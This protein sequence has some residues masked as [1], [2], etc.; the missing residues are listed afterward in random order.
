MAPAAASAC[1]AAVKAGLEAEAASLASQGELESTT[2]ASLV[3]R[4]IDPVR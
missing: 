3:R 4:T 2:A 1:R